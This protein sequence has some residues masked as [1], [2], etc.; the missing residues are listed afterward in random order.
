MDMLPPIGN[1]IEKVS[2]RPATD[3]QVGRIRMLLPTVSISRS[4]RRRA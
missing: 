2:L 4:L 1:I 3:K